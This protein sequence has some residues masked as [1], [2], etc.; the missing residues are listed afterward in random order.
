MVYSVK[1]QI[2]II[3]SS[4]ITVRAH[5]LIFKSTVYTEYTLYISLFDIQI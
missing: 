3:K 1:S 2:R 5:N 4:I